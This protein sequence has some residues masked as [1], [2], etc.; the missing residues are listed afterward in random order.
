M[1][2]S[3]DD[4]Y[5]LG[6]CA[7]SAAMQAGQLIASHAQRAVAVNTKDGGTSLAAQVVTEIDHLSQDI[8][9]QSLRPT[10]AL[11]DLALLSEESPDDGAR[12]QQ[13]YFWCIDPLDGTLPFIEGVP[14]YSVS[15]AL[16][17][18]A[19]QALIG[20][21]YDPLTQTLYRAIKDQGAWQ[22][23]QGFKSATPTQTLTFITDKSFAQDPLYHATQVELERI[24]VELG[25][26]GANLRLQGGAA[27]NACQALTKAPACYFKFPKPEKG[28]GSVWDYAATACLFREA[29]A[30]VSD[31]HGNALV[32]N[33]DGST[34]MN[35]CGVLYSS[36]QA[37]A[38]SM[39][40][41]YRQLRQG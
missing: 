7:I 27:L 34:F 36:D 17:S 21:V 14:G 37:I 41:F 29:G 18:R 35:H 28:G 23:Q 26:A 40:R 6:Q 8:I 15:I 30:P 13:D 10:C 20:V 1:R 31:I 4:L 16:V 22:N 3:T 11:Y 25:Y 24:A 2:L 38:E 19:G 32:L 39:I 12:L 33:P 5:L 9:L